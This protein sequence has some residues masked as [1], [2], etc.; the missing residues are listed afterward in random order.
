MAIIDS[1]R[2][3]SGLRRALSAASDAVDNFKQRGR[4]GNEEY[5]LTAEDMVDRAPL[6]RVKVKVGVLGYID[7]IFQNR[8]K[9]D[10]VILS[11]SR[12]RLVEEL[13]NLVLNLDEVN[14]KLAAQPPV[15][16]S[17]SYGRPAG[18]N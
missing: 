8:T 2:P 4:S 7:S 9:T 11:T 17:E 14:A 1:A 16:P 18:D 13:T 15:K 3:E 5:V 10:G 12:E 6:D